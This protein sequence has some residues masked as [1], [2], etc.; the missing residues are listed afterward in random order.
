[1][2]PKE[3]RVRVS[4][5]GSLPEWSPLLVPVPTAP[6]HPKQF[7]HWLAARGLEYMSTAAKFEIPH[8]VPNGLLVASGRRDRRWSSLKEYEE[9]LIKKYGSVAR[10][11]KF[12]AFESPHET[13]LAVDFGCGGLAPVSATIASQKET[14]LYKWLCENA[15]DYG[16]TPYLPEPWHWEFNV[17]LSAYRAGASSDEH[18]PDVCEAI[19]DPPWCRA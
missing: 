2:I 7:L 11:R 6:G 12:L 9:A 15:H 18:V 1:M 8:A 4:V 17:P 5:Y 13:A 10:G 16:W 19:G 3:N 14:D